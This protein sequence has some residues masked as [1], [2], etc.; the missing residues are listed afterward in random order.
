MDIVVVQ[1][2]HDA[3]CISH[4]AYTFGKGM[5]PTIFSPGISK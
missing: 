5:N 2:L 3:V 1:I 4:C